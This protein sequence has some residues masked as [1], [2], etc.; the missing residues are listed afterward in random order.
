MKDCVSFETARKLQ[1]A[2]I[3][4]GETAYVWVLNIN[5]KWNLE[6]SKNTDGHTPHIVR[7]VPAPSIAEIIDR[8]PDTIRDNFFFLYKKAVGYG[9][10]SFTDIFETMAIFYAEKENENLADL[11]SKLLLWAKEN[12]YV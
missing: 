2:G 1:D 3:D 5:N 7:T 9:G 10:Y 8:L 4:F 11:L 6:F 12:K